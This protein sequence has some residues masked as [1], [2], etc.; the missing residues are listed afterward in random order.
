MKV[1]SSIEGKENMKTKRYRFLWIIIIFIFI[2]CNFG[3]FPISEINIINDFYVSDDTDENF[4]SFI[5]ASDMRDYT[6]DNQ[7][8]FRGACEAISNVDNGIYM[9]SAGDIDPP[10]QVL[11]TIKKY[12]NVDYRWFP[13]V[14]N[15][16]SETPSDMQ[17]IRDY[18]N[19]IKS[20]VNIISEGPTGSK[21]TM[22]SF[23]KG[24]V[25][26][27]ILNEYYDGTSD[28]G[29]NGDIVPATYN[30][31]KSDLEQTEKD[32]IIVFGH[33]PAF[34]LADEDSGRLRHEG[35]SLN[36]HE[37]NRDAFWSLLND[38]NVTAYICGHTHNYS[39]NLNQGDV[40]WQIDSGHSRGTQDIGA[41]STFL[42]FEINDSNELVLETY[43]MDIDTGIYSVTEIVNLSNS[44]TNE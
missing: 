12:I 29:S 39:S 1:I 4:K 6:G 3:H 28:I 31:L 26:F 27:I 34:P 20:R 10:G 8:W 23:D 13:I 40:T 25:H 11:A 16:E 44:S 33:E 2:S 24:Q 17:W 18:Y 9:F 43:R 5:V 38:N 19:V 30:W 42:Q 21:E 37:E 32:I 35:D 15:H 7:N 36:I 41:K 22:Y 14:G